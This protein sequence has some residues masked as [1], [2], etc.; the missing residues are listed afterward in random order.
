ME[1]VAPRPDMK[2]TISTGR[3]GINEQSHASQPVV[4]ERAASGIIYRSTHMYRGDP[5]FSKLG[6]PWIE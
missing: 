2:I 3:T 6:P 1:D 4:G 5:I